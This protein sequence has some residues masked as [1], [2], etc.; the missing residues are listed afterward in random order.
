MVFDFKTAEAGAFG[1]ILDAGFTGASSIAGVEPGWFASNPWRWNGAGDND[2]S[3]GMRAVAHR[4]ANSHLRDAT[5]ER[6]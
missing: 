5:Y 4:S 2:C 1:L 6:N 3:M